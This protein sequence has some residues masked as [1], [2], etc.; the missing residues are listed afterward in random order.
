MA[1]EILKKIWPEWTLGK[2]IGGGAYG[3]VYEAIRNEYGVENHAAI[4][5]ISIP[6]SE[7]EVDYLLS[8]GMDM[9]ATRTHLQTIVQDFVNEI[10]LMLSLEGRPNVV[11]VKDY[12]VVEK[13]GELGWYIFILME[14]LIPFSV[15]TCDKKLSER[16]VIKLGYDICTALETCAEENI[17]HRDIK[18][19]NILVHKNGTFKLGDFGI[20]RKLEN[21]AGGLSQRYTPKYMAPEV[22]TSRYYDGRVDIYSLGIVLYELLNEKCIP[23]Q[24]NKQINYF[25]DIEQ[26]VNRRN[27]GEAI[28][29]P[30]EASPAMANLILR[31]CAYDPDMRFSSATEMKRALVS[32][33][34]GTY[35][36]VAVSNLDRPTSAR[37][38]PI[39]H[40]QTTVVRK[41]PAASSQRTGP[42]VNTFGNATKKKP[43]FPA[44]IAIMLV[45]VILVGAKNFV[46]PK[47]IDN[48]LSNVS[49]E[50]SV[51]T[52]SKNSDYQN[53]PDESSDSINEQNESYAATETERLTD[54]SQPQNLLAACPPYELVFC[55][56]PDI[57]TMA[58]EKYSN[59]ISF[60]TDLQSFALF[61]L[62]AD[63]A[64]FSFDV[65]HIDGKSMEPA[66]L[67]I[68]LDKELSFSTDLYG[69]MLPTHY[70]LLINGAKQ[71]KIEM[72]GRSQNA[73]IESYGIVNMEIIGSTN[74]DNTPINENNQQPIKEKL[75]EVCPPYETNYG[76]Y[77]ANRDVKDGSNIFYMSGEPY[78]NG[79]KLDIN[80]TNTTQA[81]F[82]IKG[83][84]NMLEFDLGHVDET[85]G[86]ILNLRIILDGIIKEHIVVNYTD[87]VTHYAIDISGVQQL[88]IEGTGQN[89]TMWGSHYGLA[90][91]TV[92]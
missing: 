42:S 74:I 80:R 27:S 1:I 64:K 84:Y 63:Y 52:T 86:D 77:S 21:M 82:N 43:I 4:K 3:V 57:I 5:I 70:E 81:I 36:N 29:A 9:T 18:P 14:L 31:A 34:N 30:S 79:F 23:F 61:N 35:Q 15:Y 60:R 75:M 8:E 67:N 55:Y 71:M 20:A 59:G 87:L 54:N 40:D 69:E 38:E 11:N 68:Y 48:Y 13:K 73:W 50:N 22:A 83:E 88:M 6:A 12:K 85:G 76:Y 53:N 10:R 46:I 92:S 19:G 41:A 37:K 51:E 7:A 45:T 32:V 89:A 28:P 25:A 58:G 17:I 24:P 72:K 78:T 26:A 39:N 62:G 56:T 65:G 91:I 44:I 2:R 66:V 33:A 49:N 16:E 47:L 90:N